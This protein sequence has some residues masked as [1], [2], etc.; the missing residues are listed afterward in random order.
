MRLARGNFISGQLLEFFIAR[1]EDD[2][3]GAWRQSEQHRACVHDGAEPASAH[4]TAATPAGSAGA[5]RTWRTARATGTAWSAGSARLRRRNRAKNGGAK[6]GTNPGS[7]AGR[8][9][10][11]RAR[12]WSAPRSL[13]V[14]GIDAEQ[15]VV[16]RQTVKDSIL[17]HR[18]IELH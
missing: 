17:Q 9:A 14:L 4:A 8:A 6:T 1:L 18:S 15:L 12:Q 16:L 10:W 2:E 5:T 3:L 7:P 11:G 13:A